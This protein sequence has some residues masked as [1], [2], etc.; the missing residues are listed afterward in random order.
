MKLT[1]QVIAS[2]A[3]DAGTRHAKDHGRESWNEADWFAAVQVSEKLWRVYDKH[4]GI[5]PPPES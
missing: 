5:T 4:H 2:A 3:W 1:P